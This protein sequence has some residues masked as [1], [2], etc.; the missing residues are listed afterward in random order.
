MALMGGI[1]FLLSMVIDIPSTVANVALVV[2]IIGMV[3]IIA[4]GGR[5]SKSIGGKLAGG[6][7]SLYGITSYVGDFVS[8]SRL[9]ALGLAG[10]FIAVAMNMIMSMLFNA[11]PLGIIPGVIIFI[12]G[13][14]FNLFL[15]T[16]GAYVHTA[17]L[18]YVEFFGKFYEG[19]GKAF[20]TFRNKSKYINMD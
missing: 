5:E 20:K 18:T 7:Y 11:G 8:Y 6:V 19:G 16:L 10:G 3:G 17:R 2:M 14:I 1:G 4:T 12:G 15:S 13:H 9:M